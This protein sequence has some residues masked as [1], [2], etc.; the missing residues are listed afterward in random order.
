MSFIHDNVSLP[1]EI[2]GSKIETDFF[3]IVY[4][5]RP[6]KFV[7]LSLAVI[8]FPIKMSLL[9]SITWYERFGCDLKRTLINK[10]VSSTCWSGIGL[11]T[12]A[13]SL[14]LIRFT[15]GPLPKPVCWIKSLIVSASL[16]N[17]LVFIDAIILARFVFIFV[18]KNP[19]ALHDDFW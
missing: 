9:Y 2:N 18:L 16:A 10:F 6:S 15:F 1:M 4:Q 14:N 12:F 11:I 3:E 7:I 8:L 17:I 5:N 19:A 13:L